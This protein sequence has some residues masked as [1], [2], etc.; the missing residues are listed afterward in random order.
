MLRTSV[1]TGVLSNVER[2]LASSE[3]VKASSMLPFRCATTC[4][5]IVG[6]M[7]VSFEYGS[8]VCSKGIFKRTFR[9]LQFNLAHMKV[10]TAHISLLASVTL[11]SRTRYKRI[12]FLTNYRNCRLYKANRTHLKG[13]LPLSVPVASFGSKGFRP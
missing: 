3:F 13:I 4:C 8:I 6:G 1:R 7:W 10:G 5:G 9:K 2:A 12:I 11:S